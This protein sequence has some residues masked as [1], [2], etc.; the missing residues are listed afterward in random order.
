MDRNTAHRP[1]ELFP[2]PVAAGARIYGGHVVCADA[3]GFAVL[4]ATGLTVLGVA[5][6]FADNRDGEQGAVLVM[7]RRGLA[8]HLGNDPAKPV[9]QAHTGKLCDLKDSTTVCAAAENSSTPAG[10]VLEVTT[11]GVWVLTA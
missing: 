11:D 4:G 8:F 5:D 6:D 7:V 10:R 9:T 1:G 3:S 2:V